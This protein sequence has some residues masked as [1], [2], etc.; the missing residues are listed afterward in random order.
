MTPNEAKGRRRA[1]AR[2][3]LAAETIGVDLFVT[4]REYLLK[5]NHYSS[6]KVAVCGPEEA[7]A[8]IGLYLRT[9]GVSD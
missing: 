6:D 8:L 9:Q 1:D 2:A 3:Y 4:H 5:S 7:L